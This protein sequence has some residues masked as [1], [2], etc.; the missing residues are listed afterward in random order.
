M[1]T[2]IQE[3]HSEMVRVL[4]KDP[5]AIVASLTPEKMHLLHMAS[6]LCAEAG[7]LMGAIGAHIYYEKELD[8]ENCLEELGDIEFYLEGLRQGLMLTRNNPLVHNLQKLAKRYEGF[9]YSNEAAI[10]RAD[11]K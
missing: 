6:K 2:T 11:K 7:E 1:D 3:D 4:C 9:K 5:K 8:V 10:D